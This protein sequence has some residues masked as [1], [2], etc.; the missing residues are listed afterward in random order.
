VVGVAA[1]AVVEVAVVDRGVAIVVADV[2]GAG[3]P[4][5][6]SAIVVVMSSGAVVVET[7]A[8]GPEHAEI[9]RS[10]TSTKRMLLTDQ[11][12]AISDPLTPDT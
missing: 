8:D 1:G 12:Y 7:S 11:G 10:T 2:D 5:G 4:V 3:V 6:A 9:V